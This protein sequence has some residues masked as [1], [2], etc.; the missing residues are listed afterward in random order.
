MMNDHSIVDSDH[1]SLMESETINDKSWKKIERLRLYSYILHELGNMIPLGFL[2]K[3]EKCWG[4]KNLT[5]LGKNQSYFFI[6]GLNMSL[7]Y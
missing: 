4:Y 1:M 6:S 3:S 2:S 5:I 7:T